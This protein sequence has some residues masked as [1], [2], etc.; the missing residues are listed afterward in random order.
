MV[1][2]QPGKDDYPKLNAYSSISLLSCMGTVVEK[3][4]MELLSEEAERRG[5]LS[6]G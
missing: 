6:D 4:A 2:C 5:L 1:I 3:V